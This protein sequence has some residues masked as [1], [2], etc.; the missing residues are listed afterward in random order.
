MRRMPGSELGSF[1]SSAFP[2]GR[3]AVRA[4]H[5]WRSE[6][7]AMWPT[8]RSKLFAVGLLL[9]L[10]GCGQP[11]LNGPTDAAV[12]P[13]PLEGSYFHRPEIHDSHLI[14]LLPDG[15]ARG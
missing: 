3:W 8:A 13:A 5:C 9:V 12:V 4:I 15:G 1:S 6:L 7:G 14:Q 10:G 11:G 2:A